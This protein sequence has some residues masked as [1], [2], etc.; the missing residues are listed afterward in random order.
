MQESLR[1]PL[2]VHAADYADKHQEGKGAALWLLTTKAGFE[3][4]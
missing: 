3:K 1:V 2:I 4:L